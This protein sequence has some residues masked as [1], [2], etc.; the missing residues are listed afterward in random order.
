MGSPQ[1]APVPATVVITPLGVTSRIRLS[2]VSAM[3]TSPLAST[4]TPSGS[5]RRALVAGPPS[6]QTDGPVGSPQFAPVPATVVMTPLGVISRT[7]PS[8]VSA[9]N[10]SPF[11]STATASGSSK[12][13]SIASPPS[14]H[15]AVAAVGLPQVAPV[16]PIV[17]IV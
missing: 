15:A 16:P 10:T 7:R 17:Q 13:A 11:E 1:F 14:P 6:P 5:S 4:A 8:N 12:V 2:P 9:M 3:K